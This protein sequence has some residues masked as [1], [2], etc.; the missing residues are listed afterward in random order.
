MSEKKPGFASIS[1]QN[2]EVLILGT[3]PGA[4]SLERNE[5]YAHPRNR[6]WR[7]VA[8][9]KKEKFPE[10]YA[11]KTKLL[12]KHKIGVWDIAHQ[13]KREGSL[14]V[15]ILEIIPNNLTD[16]IS[17]HKNLKVVGFNGGKAEQLF[18]QHF[19]E[20]RH[21]KYKLLLSTSPA[22]ARYSYDEILDNWRQVLML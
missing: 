14:D 15:N 19:E 22:N 8:D 17:K 2:T 3:F 12:L 9:I 21:I 18:N 10:N 7:I 13:A 1:N 16:F 6:F 4:M 20:E 11:E 5:Y